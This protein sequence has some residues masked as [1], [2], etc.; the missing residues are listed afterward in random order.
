LASKLEL[1]W[2][3]DDFSF[4]DAL[5]FH[6]A[7]ARAVSRELDGDRLPVPARRD[8]LTF[9][10]AR[11]QFL[12]RR[13]SFVRVEPVVG[14]WYPSRLL[15]N[16]PCVTTGFRVVG[17]HGETLRIDANH[18]LAGR[19][20]EALVSDTEVAAALDG[21]REALPRSKLSAWLSSGVGLQ[22][23][24]ADF[25]AGDALTRVDA[26]VDSQFYAMPRLV[27]HIDSHC[28][29]TITDLYG[30]LI[31]PGGDVLDLMSSWVSHLPGDLE[32]G[33]VRGLGMNRDELAANPRL[34]DFVVHDLNRLPRLPFDDASFDAIVCTVSVEYLTQPRAIFSEAARVLRRGGQFVNTFSERCFPTKA[35][36][37]W[38]EIDPYERVALVAEH[39]RSTGLFDQCQA[40]ALSGLPRPPDDPYHEMSLMADPVYAVWGVKT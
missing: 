27:Q 22:A 36:K 37:V 13:S 1:R 26:A 14:R 35:I 9:E 28:R 12:S 17:D 40:W 23:S 20:V 7:D 6:N 31:A 25:L 24:R 33:C 2:R 38:G 29:A 15:D 11:D 10:I 30:A 4:T 39:Y 3:E 21:F 34:D 18:P 32:L 5:Y 19:V 8:D 16:H